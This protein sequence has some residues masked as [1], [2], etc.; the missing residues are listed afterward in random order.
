MTSLKKHE[1][2]L[3]QKTIAARQ[4]RL[5]SSVI[6]EELQM[7]KSKQAGHRASTASLQGSAERQMNKSSSLPTLGTSEFSPKSSHTGASMLLSPKDSRPL[8]S[9][10]QTHSNFEMEKKGHSA[11]H[12][13]KD[14]QALVE[15]LSHRSVT[16][17]TQLRKLQFSVSKSLEAGASH[18]PHTTQGN[19]RPPSSARH[20]TQLPPGSP[21]VDP[22]TQRPVGDENFFMPKRKILLPN[23]ASLQDIYESKRRDMWGQIIK[24]QYKEDEANKVSNRQKKLEADHKY[25]VLLTNQ[26]LENEARRR[27]AL[28]E[29][30][31]FALIE[32]A[33]AKGYEDLEKNRQADAVRRHK[34]FIQNALEDIQVKHTRK[35]QDLTEELTASAIMIRKARD[36][37]HDEE[38][39]QRKHR[40]FMKAYQ[41]KIYQENL[42]DLRRKQEN[43][44]KSQEEDKRIIEENENQYRKEMERRERELQAKMVRSTEGPAHHI[45]E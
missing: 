29:R 36:A 42:D 40:D 34:E 24:A 19:N 7:M 13:S 45:V 10:S 15:E 1:L 5:Q 39:R 20:S 33:H 22:E 3:A 44:L 12:M 28:Q 35:M 8:P 30:D 4:V 37:V 27:R 23:G 11:S 43:K 41:D 26:V 2:V 32:G 17:K 25:G 18:R 6:K 14:N 31:Q 9:P 16:D 21:M 38:E